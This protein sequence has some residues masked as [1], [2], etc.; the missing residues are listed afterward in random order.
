MYIWICFMTF[1]PHREPLKYLSYRLSKEKPQKI[2][3]FS[4]FKIKL[5]K[6]KPLKMCV[7]RILI[8]ER[9]QK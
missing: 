7:F 4:F 9:P 5:S 6:E 3:I 8:L 2:Y 1:F